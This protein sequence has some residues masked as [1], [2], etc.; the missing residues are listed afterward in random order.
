MR[1]GMSA[2]LYTLLPATST[3]APFSTATLAVS[4]PMPPSTSSSQAGFSA[5]I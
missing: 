5:S 4:G 2:A 1:P 3:L